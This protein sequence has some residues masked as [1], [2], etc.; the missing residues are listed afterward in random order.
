VDHRIPLSQGGPD[1]PANMQWLTI[2][3]HEAKTASERRRQ[4]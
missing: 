1:D 4:Q 2:A 3:E